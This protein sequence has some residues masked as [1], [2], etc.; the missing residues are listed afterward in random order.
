MTR[1]L[2]VL[3]TVA[4]AVFSVSVSPASAGGIAGGPELPPV[5]DPP[6][7]GC[8]GCGG[9]ISPGVAPWEWQRN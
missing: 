8:V 2:V 7:E 1:R 6:T 5:A 3:L 4:L 9:L